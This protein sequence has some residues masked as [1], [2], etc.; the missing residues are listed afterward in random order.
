MTDIDLHDL[1]KSLSPLSELRPSTVES[2]ARA[3]RQLTVPRGGYL[4]QEG[5]TAGFLFMVASGSFRVEKRSQDGAQVVVRE[6]GA[7]EVGGL[8]SMHVEKTRSATLRALST[9]QVVVIPREAF[10]QTL[11]ESPDLARVLLIHLSHKVREKSRTLATLLSRVQPDP[12][13]K[14]AFFD[15]K[16]YERA[17]FAARLSEDLQAQYFEARLG[18]PTAALARGFPVVCT[19]V[20][21]V[22]D[23][24]VIEQLVAG[25]TGLLALRCAGFNNVDLRA[26]GAAGL[27]VVRVPAYSPHAVAEHTAALIMCLNRKIHRAYNRVREG[28]F[29]LS[30]LV[31]FDLHGR[32]AGVVGLGKIG[33]CL[34]AILRGF[35][36]KVLAYDPYVN[37]SQ[38]REAGV[39]CVPLDELLSTSDIVSLHSPLTPETY[40]L[41]DRER[42]ST[43]KRGAMLINT[44]RGGLV[45]SA[46]LIEGLKSGHIGAAGLDVYEQESEYFFQDRSDRVITDDF[47]ARLM[48]FNNVIVTSHQAFLTTDALDNI[49]ET[50]V[51]NVRAFLAGARGAELPNVVTSA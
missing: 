21:D 25:G 44:S 47:L 5:D 17:A 6:M 49:A 39:R 7:G 42:L 22:V 28:N 18:P 10:L 12:R 36:M 8:T 32:T 35:G 29:S 9:A 46:A 19:F 50:T 15:A 14:I 4:F 34:A 38:T 11:R 26:A 30:G 40:H 13:V 33:L 16:P 23:A 41:I 51:D 20:N 24:P 45:D 37:D 43:M 31:G 27:S 1:F 3:A 2:L 48:T